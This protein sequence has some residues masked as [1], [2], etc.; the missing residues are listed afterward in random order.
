LVHP[1]LAKL[2]R[3]KIETL[4]DALEARDIRLGQ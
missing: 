1:N 2:Y 3:D 4:A